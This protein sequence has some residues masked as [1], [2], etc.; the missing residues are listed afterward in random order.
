[1]SEFQW[2]TSSRSTQGGQCV[3]TAGRCGAALIRDSRL[4]DRSPVLSVAPAAFGRFVDA[5]KS[6]GFQ[7]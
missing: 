7:R 2:K 4:G 3:Q 6:G 1:M 5:I